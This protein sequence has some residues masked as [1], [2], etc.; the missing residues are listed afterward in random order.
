MYAIYYENGKQSGF[1]HNASFDRETDSDSTNVEF[2]FSKNG[3]ILLPNLDDAKT[4]LGVM[5]AGTAYIVKVEWSR[6][7]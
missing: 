5:E 3:P 6:V 2:V 1:L 7:E 4:I